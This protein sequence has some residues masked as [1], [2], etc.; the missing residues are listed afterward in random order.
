MDMIIRE[1]GQG[2]EASIA[3]LVRELAR[4]AGES[5][6]VSPATVREFLEFPGCGILLAEESGQA[7]GLLSYSLRPNLY[8]AARCCMIEE[9]VIREGARGRGLG[10][11]LLR[12]LFRRVT[13]PGCAEISVS[14]MTDNLGAQ[15]FYRAH[16]L[17]DEA[18]L[19]EKHL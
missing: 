12:E 2:D 17:V 1:A 13:A 18:V 19:L 9:L 4:S 11:S 10:D 7:L 16:G 3:D 5:S 8:H 15:R 6:P 14:T